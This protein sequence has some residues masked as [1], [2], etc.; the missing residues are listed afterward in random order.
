MA[1][2]GVAPFVLAVACLL[3]CGLAARPAQVD[4]AEEVPRSI[5]IV[6]PAAALEH[7]A[8][9]TQGEN[10]TAFHCNDF[11]VACGNGKHIYVSRAQSALQIASKLM[12]LN[13]YTA[14]AKITYHMIRGL[15][16]EL[17]N[18]CPNVEMVQVRNSRLHTYD[19]TDDTKRYGSLPLLRKNMNALHRRIH[20]CT[21]CFAKDGALPEEISDEFNQRPDLC[22]Q[23]GGYVGVDKEY[24]WT[25][26]LKGKG[27]KI[28]ECLSM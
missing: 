5:E 6:E 13:I 19:I 4:E 7:D 1:R 17:P 26:L 15:M 20:D 9:V 14:A 3:S 18:E 27:N 11:C 16:S 25:S 28:T 2:A 12:Y 10:E 24:G 23:D 22:G 21:F 8:D